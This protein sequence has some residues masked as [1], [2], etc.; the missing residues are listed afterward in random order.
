MKIRF[1]ALVFLIQLPLVGF[2]ETVYLQIGLDK[3]ECKNVIL[4]VFAI[5]GDIDNAFE[6]YK[7]GKIISLHEGTREIWYNCET[8][9]EQKNRSCA[10]TASLDYQARE[11]LFKAGSYKAY[12][13]NEKELKIETKS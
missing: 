7:Y 5:D 1:L 6:K 4:N 13:N 8:R 10:Y 9:I 11:V 2:A 12:C 3:S